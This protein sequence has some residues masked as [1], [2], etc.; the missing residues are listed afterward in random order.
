MSGAG[1]AQCGHLEEGSEACGA[2]GRQA[3]LPE[4]SIRAG[5]EIP[6]RKSGTLVRTL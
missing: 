2:P 1:G 5:F 4:R 3:V 6:R